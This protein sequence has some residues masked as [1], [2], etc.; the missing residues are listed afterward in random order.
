VL[1]LEHREP[2]SQ[3]KV[4]NYQALA[5]MKTAAETSLSKF[6]NGQTC[7]SFIAQYRLRKFRNLLISEPHGILANNWDKF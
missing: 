4:F 6:A 1:A 2:L 7:L 5:R 3:G